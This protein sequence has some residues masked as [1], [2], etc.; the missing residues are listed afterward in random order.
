MHP[1]ADAEDMSVNIQP[2]SFINSERLR[3]GKYPL[4]D[5]VFYRW[6]RRIEETLFQKI[7]VEVYGGASV[8]EE[9]KFSSFFSM[10]KQARPIYFFEMAPFPGNGL[11][12]LDNR[13][14]AFCLRQQQGEARV[15][16]EAKLSHGNQG[17]L[18]AIV[19]SLMAEF[20]RSWN[21]IHGVETR[22]T[23][24]TTYPFRARILNPY[25]NCLVAQI[26]LSGKGFSSRI[27]WCL[28]SKMLQ[29]VIS[30]LKEAKVIPPVGIDTA[31]EDGFT[32]AEVLERIQYAM[33]IQ[34]GGVDL[35]RLKKN[36][37]VGQIIPIETE[38]GNQAI[39]NLDGN[40]TLIASIGQA[41]M[42]RAIKVNQKHPPPS[43]S[44]L[45]NPSEFR[46]SDWP[47]ANL[48]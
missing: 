47:T 20:D 22:L 42:H 48:D 1:L 27:I 10:L 43:R 35:T 41:G 9:M 44:G 7:Q 38:A 45:V 39:V 11:L 40:P 37:E 5:T 6:T 2:Y 16:V 29:P 14:T 15:R 13:F 31:P 32:E 24:I 18:Q 46:E 4:L 34:L 33:K 30:R 19:Q 28:P 36:L 26:H 8:V 21:E 17:R 3:Y 12:V 23:K 25:E